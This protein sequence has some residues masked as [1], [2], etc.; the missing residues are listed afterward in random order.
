MPTV[1]IDSYDNWKEASSSGTYNQVLEFPLFTDVGE[2]FGQIA[3]RDG[4]PYEI[5]NTLVDNR[6]NTFLPRMVLR[7]YQH[8]VPLYDTNRWNCY[9]LKEESDLNNQPPS[10]ESIVFIEG[11]ENNYKIKI[12]INGDWLKMDMN[13]SKEYL[14]NITKPVDITGLLEKT[15]ELKRVISNLIC[16]HKLSEYYSD[17]N[18]PEQIAA[19]L[20]LVYGIRISAG[21]LSRRS[22]HDTDL[23]IPVNYHVYKNPLPIKYMNHCHL[24]LPSAMRLSS[25][26][27]CLN[28]TTSTEA[29]F[30][31]V[32]LKRDQA[33][34]ILRCAKLYTDALSTVE[35]DT[36]LS[37]IRLVSSV[38]IAA[39]QWRKDEN[40][41][42]DVN[43]LREK[44]SDIATLLVNSSTNTDQN[45]I[46]NTSAINEKRG[47]EIKF[48]AFILRF[49]P[50]KPPE[51]RPFGFHSIG[52]YNR[53][54]T[55][56]IGFWDQESILKILRG[57]YNHRSR[58]LHGGIPFPPRMCK[59]PIKIE[60]SGVLSERSMQIAPDEDAVLICTFEYIV[61]ESLIKWLIDMASS[62][63]PS[64]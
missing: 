54:T 1:Y 61:R 3:K 38:E 43:N 6:E 13:T 40:I 59:A 32:Y 57:I 8:L 45:P 24:I 41:N 22:T 34:A 16:Y 12:S 25:S 46:N 58:A 26:T 53:T 4:C 60:E 63:H 35:S 50:N 23:G 64:G 19:L 37:W 48:C 11:K 51:K 52:Y 2:I 42:G 47:A 17:I 9:I 29:F 36:S 5:I 27:N 10:E 56:S 14:D 20:S 21:S 15:D 55:E 7:I 28:I 33:L 49:L 44:Y 30:K 62:N 31:F 18:E 39:E